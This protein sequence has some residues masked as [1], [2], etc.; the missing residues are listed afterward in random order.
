MANQR[1]P[2]FIQLALSFFLTAG[3]LL[4]G[5]EA[6]QSFD[7]TVT[8]SS[9]PADSTI[10]AFTP[11]AIDT[12]SLPVGTGD[13]LP[14]SLPI[15][16][17]NVG[18]IQLFASIPENPE[19]LYRI[20]SDQ[21]WLFVADTHG[22]NVFDL[23]TN[24]LERHLPFGIVY[25]AFPNELDP[26]GINES[27]FSIAANGGVLA[28]VDSEGVKVISREGALLFSS[29]LEMPLSPDL[30]PRSVPMRVSLALS[31]EGEYLALSRSGAGIDVI[32]LS[33]GAILETPGLVGSFPRFSPG[34]GTLVFMNGPSLEF[35]DTT[36]WTFIQEIPYRGYWPLFTFSDDS[37]ILLHTWSNSLEVWDLIPREK[38]LTIGLEG[39]P[40]KSIVLAQPL[41]SPG[42]EFL[43]VMKRDNELPCFELSPITVT[44]LNRNGQIL[45]EQATPFESRNCQPYFL[46]LTYISAPILLTDSGEVI[47]VLPA[48]PE[49]QW[50]GEILQGTAPSSADR[51]LPSIVEVYLQRNWSD[52][53]VDFVPSPDGRYVI[54]SL[55]KETGSA[56][57]I[58][59]VAQDRPIYWGGA[60]FT[61]GSFSPDSAMFAMTLWNTLQTIDLASSQ[62]LQFRTLYDDRDLVPDAPLAVSPDRRLLA[63]VIARDAV[64]ETVGFF[65]IDDGALLVQWPAGNDEIQQLRFSED[66]KYLIVSTYGGWID[67]LGVL[68]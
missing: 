38:I 65:S 43:A 55:R 9:A 48:E 24:T 39:D 50:D 20:S 64:S 7:A 47:P 53:D 68:P 22:I 17:A 59:D 21:K 13:P 54:L 12:D 32:R 37:T 58:Y 51:I 34:G 46:G 29:A 61:A 8:P 15:D 28:L 3:W 57:V 44:V 33:D 56:F 45:S 11:A 41:V 5:C 27:Q 18:Q 16:P 2:K 30:P 1:F 62:E 10:S 25:N 52:F 19:R 35:W 42:A 63:A 23:G 14:A 40:R 31:P 26:S 60:A 49:N 36:T 66:G 6:R 67:V 4:A